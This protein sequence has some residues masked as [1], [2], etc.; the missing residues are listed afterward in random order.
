MVKFINFFDILIS[1]IAIIDSGLHMPYNPA[2]PFEVPLL[3]PREE[4]ETSAVLKAL[5]DAGREIGELKGYCYTLPNPMLLMSLAITKESVES[6]RIEDIVTTVESV[7]EGQGL[8]ESEVK[9]PDKEVLRYRE[10]MHWGMA[11]LK[12]YSISTRLILGIHKKLIPGSAGYRQQQNAIKNQRTGEVVYTPPPATEIDR[13]LQNWENFVNAKDAASPLDPLIRCALAHYQFEAIH[14]F[15]DGNGRTGRIL[16]VL[17]LVQE[18]LLSY[19][20]LYISGFLNKHR[21]D[22]YETLSDVTR[23]G[24]WEDFILFML[25]GFELQ[26]RKTKV[27]LLEV[28]IIYEKLKEKIRNNHTRMKAEETADHIF[29]NVVTHPAHLA[30]ELGIH[31]QTA[32]RHLAELSKARLFRDFWAGRKHFY[33]YP[34]LWDLTEK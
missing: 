1:N 25:D 10:A 16:L 31:H 33:Y 2:K 32:S 7:L 21:D 6:S 4:L 30:R 34:E 12:Q 19:P 18:R 22:Y 3:P 26:A 11:N 14:P 29:S 9:A 27:K 13:L 20:V 24:N 8:P 28:M 23:N 5:V 17:Q 15:I